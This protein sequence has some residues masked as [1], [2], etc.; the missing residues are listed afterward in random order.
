[1]GKNLLGQKEIIEQCLQNS[2]QAQYRLYE[3]YSPSMFGICLRYAK[4]STDAEDIL[5][6]GFI[7]VFRYLKDYSGK[8]SFEGWMRKIMINSALN[9]Y[10]RKNLISKGIEPEEAQHFLMHDFNH[11]VLSKMDHEELL[12]LIHDLP[13]GY[14]TVFNL[15]IIEGYSHKEIGDMMQISVNTS[16]SQLSRARSSLKRRVKELLSSEESKIRWVAQTA[17]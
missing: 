16:K 7:K 11:D 8:G 5:Q 12:K 9:Y 13:D 17:W 4:N 6:E 2:R 10:K 3:K 14:R 15:N 1:M